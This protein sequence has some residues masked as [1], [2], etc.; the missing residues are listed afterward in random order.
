MFS[1]VTDNLKII[2]HCS[3]AHMCQSILAQPLIVYLI[4]A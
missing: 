2:D 4:K 3:I 1:K